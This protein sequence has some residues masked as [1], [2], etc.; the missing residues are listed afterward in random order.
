MTQLDDF[1]VDNENEDKLG[2]DEEAMIET[3]DAD[4]FIDPND[5]DKE[6]ALAE[7]VTPELDI[8]ELVKDNKK[9]E[10]E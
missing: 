10:E 3:V 1:E 7:T 8:N 6:E 2:G 4:K 9:I 5:N